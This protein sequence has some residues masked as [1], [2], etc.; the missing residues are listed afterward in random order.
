[1]TTS[2]ERTGRQPDPVGDI[3]AA[4][5]PRPASGGPGP[6]LGHGERHFSHR[7]GWLRASVLGANDGIVSTAALVLGVAA[8][9]ASRSAVLTA[10]VAGGVAG[11]L[12]MALGEYVSVSSQRDSEQADIAKER[13][14][15]EHVP[16]RELAELTA[17]Y[18]EKGL[19]P[20]LARQVAEELHRVDPLRAHLVEELG[21]T[22]QMQAR[23]F[24]AAWSSAASFSVGA[25][26]PLLA[27]ALAGS[28]VRI[29][30]ILIAAL[31]ALT[32]LGTLGALAGGASP[33]RPTARVVIGGAVAMGLTMLIGHLI[34]TAV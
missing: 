13:W 22:E 12:S 7:V 11:A 3:P 8:A 9:E 31:L 19:S 24:Q 27:A 14:E 28:S 2:G 34:G 32:V 21:I 26:L 20:E 1:M 23:P 30:V 15:L 16:E 5:T 18:R 6:A 10:G 33:Y 4:S 25:A 29:A 17:I